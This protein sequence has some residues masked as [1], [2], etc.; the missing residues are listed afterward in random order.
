[1]RLSKL[2]ICSLLI[3]ALA[4]PMALGESKESIVTEEPAYKPIDTPTEIPKEQPADTP[5]QE[6]TSGPAQDPEPSATTEPTITPEPTVA[7]TPTTTPEPT[8]FPPTEPGIPGE[9]V[10]IT[11]EGNAKFADDAWEIALNAQDAGVDFSWI[12]EGTAEKFYLFA[13]SDYLGETTEYRASVSSQPYMNGQ[14]TLYVGALLDDGSITWG[15][16]NFRITSDGKPS[17]GFPGGRPSG[18]NRPSGSGAAGTSAE[19]QGFHITPGKALTSKHSSGTKN[20]AAYTCSEINDSAEAITALVL[21]S[22]Q[23]EIK[24]DGGAAFFAFKDD[25][26]LQLMPESD[27]ACWQLTVLAMNTLAESGIDRVV[28]HVGGTAYSIPTR[29]EFNGSVY[30]SLRAKGYV[31]KDMEIGID[32]PGVHVFVDGFSYRINEADELVPYEE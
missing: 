16:V 22:T 15:A 4:L 7:P 30:A 18:G 28:F 29:M 12:V 1:M 13:D 2:L 27:G 14:H 9:L 6:P 23:T 19:E 26:T 32:A 17:G 25:G 31:S 11:C 3:C 21:E 24:L 10:V 5:T 20:T 8:F